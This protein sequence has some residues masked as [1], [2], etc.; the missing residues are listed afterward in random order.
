MNS[1]NNSSSLTHAIY[2]VGVAKRVLD[3]VALT[4]IAWLA[5]LRAVEESNKNGLVHETKA[6]ASCIIYLLFFSVPTS[7]PTS[8]FVY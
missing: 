5:G 1:S 2:V 4:A 7:P 6:H 3:S 8:S